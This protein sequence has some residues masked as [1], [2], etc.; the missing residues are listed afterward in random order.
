MSVNKKLIRRLRREDG[1]FTIL[2]KSVSSSLVDLCD[3][4]GR[5]ECE[6]RK[7]LDHATDKGYGV[8]MELCSHY[9]APLVFRDTIGLER[10]GACVNTF[11][12]GET[13]M[14]RLKPGDKVALVDADGK[15]WGTALVESVYSGLKNDMYR[16]HAY[17]N[18]AVVHLPL[19]ERN[20][21]L[22]E[23]MRQA[24][25]LFIKNTTHLTA[26]YLKRVS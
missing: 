13:W 5:E 24:Y 18:H 11:R 16:A 6:I 20:K 22:K 21:A 4:C 17:R 8:I 14:A 25:G 19:S 3:A 2:S 26:I 9:M 1:G 23:I 7:A 10:V 12:T 15:V